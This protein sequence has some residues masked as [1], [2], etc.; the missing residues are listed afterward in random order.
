MLA[1]GDKSY[2]HFCACGKRLDARLEALGAKRIFDRFD[3]DREVGLLRMG[4][5]G[6]R[7][8]PHARPPC[9]QDWERV[10][11]WIDGVLQA[12]VASG[13]KPTAAPAAP[14]AAAPAAAAAANGDAHAAAAKKKYTRSHPYL[15]TVTQVRGL[16]TLREKD[17]KDTVL[18][19]L[20][21][22]DSGLEYLPGDALGIVPR[23]CSRKVGELL[24]AWGKDGEEEVPTP[25]WKGQ[26]GPGVAAAGTLPLRAALCTCYDLR[27]IKA[28]IFNIMA[29][30][31]EAAGG[32]PASR[33][34]CLTPRA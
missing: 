20:D 15:A 30:G 11:Q 17:D 22:G 26:V 29:R 7:K 16:C 4:G 21:L 32:E 25:G 6:R 19:E 28:D 5:S 9:V 13:I 34:P 33:P 12:L 8:E 27:D 23:N 10:N 18:V 24:A 14:T 2:Q 3:I 31:Y 1:L